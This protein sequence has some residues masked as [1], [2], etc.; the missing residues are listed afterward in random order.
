MAETG[1]ISE[2]Q[3]TEA[4]ATPLQISS[5]KGRIDTTDAPYFADYVQNQLGDLIADQGTAQHLRI[6]TSVDMQLQRAAYAA[7]T[8][9]L[10]ALDKIYAKRGVASG[11]V[12]GRA[13]CAESPYR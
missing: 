10:V 12:A 9:Q 2:Q 6:Y 5:G 3:F 11:N 13:G 7:V 4:V 1:V 8:K